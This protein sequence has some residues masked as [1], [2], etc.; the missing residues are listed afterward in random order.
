MVEDGRT[1]KDVNQEKHQIPA[2][3]DERRTQEAREGRAK[4][5][6]RRKQATVLRGEGS[7]A[8]GP[9]VARD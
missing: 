4:G 8:R 1:G 9:A 7:K 5:E 2:E 3:C 6:G